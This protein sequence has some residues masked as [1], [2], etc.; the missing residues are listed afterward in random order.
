MHLGGYTLSTLH[1]RN[2]SIWEPKMVKTAT[3]LRN[4][5]SL[6][7][8][9]HSTLP[10]MVQGTVGCGKSFMIHELASSM[11][12]EQTLLELHLDDQTM[13]RLS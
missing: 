3:S 13:L 2:E 8:A 4:F 12:Q 11:G 1:A 10:I 5:Q 9:I 6:M 7:Q